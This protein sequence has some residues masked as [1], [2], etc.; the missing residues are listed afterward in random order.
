MTCQELAVEVAHQE[1]RELPEPQRASF[2]DHV[3]LCPPCK[4]YLDTYR[5][6]IALG[7]AVCADPQGPVP[8]DVPDE[9]VEAILAARSRV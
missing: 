2:A 1:V 5:E 6:T 8:Q 7:K 4:A 9:L 3:D